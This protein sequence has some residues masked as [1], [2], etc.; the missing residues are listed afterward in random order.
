MPT[1]DGD[2]IERFFNLHLKY[3]DSCV[4]IMALNAGY[5]VGRGIVRSAKETA[6]GG[7]FTNPYEIAAEVSRLENVSAYWTVNPVLI[8]R[9]PRDGRNNLR[10]LRKNEG[11][12]D[13]DIKIIRY[14]VIDID[15]RSRLVKGSSTDEEL[16]D[17]LAIRDRIVIDR[18]LADHSMVGMSGNGGLVIVRLPDMPNDEMTR[19]S[20]ASYIDSLSFYKGELGAHVDTQKSV[21]APCRMIAIPGTRKCKGDYETPTNPWR[22]AT[23]DI[24][25]DIIPFDLPGWVER[26]GLTCTPEGERKVVPRKARDAYGQAREWLFGGTVQVSEEGQHGHNRAFYV[27][28]ELVHGFDL[29]ESDAL[30]LMKEWNHGCSPPWSDSDLIHKI[31]E[32]NAK[33]CSKPRGY[34]IN[35]KK[36]KV[37]FDQSDF[38]DGRDEAPPVSPPDRPP[39]EPPWKPPPSP[40]KDDGNIDDPVYLA[41][42]FAK[43]NAAAPGF[44]RYRYHSERWWEWNDSHY[45][46][47]S[48]KKF[49]SVLLLYIDT[50]LDAY[51]RELYAGAGPDDQVKPKRLTNP[52]REQTKVAL[53][54][55]VS[56]DTESMSD[57]F[58]IGRPLVDWKPENIVPFSNRLLNIPAFA[59]GEPRSWIKKTP[60]L[61]NTYSLDYRFPFDSYDGPIDP[62]PVFASY[63]SRAL[64]DDAEAIQCYREMLGY[65]IVPSNRFQKMF[66]LIGPKR[67]GKGTTLRI[68]E[69]MIG[70]K[71]VAFP[72]FSSLA[73]VPFGRQQLLGK[74]VAIMGDAR[75]SGRTDVQSVVE[76]ILG[77]TGNDPQTIARKYI[78]DVT[79]RLFCRFVISSNSLPRLSDQSGALVSRA[80]IFRFDNSVY[81][82]EDPDLEEKMIPEI[83]M[84]FRW[85]IDG[86]IS[87][88]ERGKFIQPASGQDLVDELTRLSSTV[89]HFKEECLD[90]G[91]T[92][93]VS[94]RTLY[95]AYKE[96][97][98]GQGK[99]YA[100]DMAGFLRDLTSAIPGSRIKSDYVLGCS[101]KSNGTYYP[102]Y[103]GNI[104][105]MPS[106]RQTIDRLGDF[107]L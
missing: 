38:T 26:Y 99:E 106:T 29:S 77:I 55:L 93:S 21:S 45:K 39:P 96:W 78:D 87:L 54:G 58:W 11:A 33:P 14:M 61:F 86:W 80:I 67:T 28:C 63:L 27:A 95:A 59:K 6:F 69:H 84:I 37:T 31:E 42:M 22:I 71:N 83:P 5:G 17:C 94:T 73:V 1:V 18:T 104:Q 43:E 92:L 57:C 85:A 35:K 20:I 13:Q 105:A 100:T 91:A 2:Q 12:K 62:P 65:L 72:T 64:K 66:M 60:N 23:I 8:D 52:L 19:A 7:W 3:P 16:Q 47:L 50:K 75:L 15:P 25:D 10:M 44:C 51:N 68:I 102:V 107:E 79:M 46:P 49:D 36:I 4:E 34:R 98:K 81:G 97:S 76:T 53:R 30:S 9:R 70:T 48:E 82:E 32:A 56:I 41:T 40:G 89:L 103:N 90:V 88:H 24:K 74:M 101:L